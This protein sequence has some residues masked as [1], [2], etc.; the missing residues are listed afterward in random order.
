[1]TNFKKIINNLEKIEVDNFFRTN[2][3]RVSYVLAIG[4]SLFGD[5]QIAVFRDE[6][7]GSIWSLD[8]GYYIEEDLNPSLSNT[9]SVREHQNIL[10]HINKGIEYFKKG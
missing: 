8:L 3:N 6:A 4:P 5:T 7:S 10:Y 9:L 2:N 1:M